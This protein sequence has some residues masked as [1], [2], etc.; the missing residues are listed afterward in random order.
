MV[1]QSKRE[2]LAAILTRYGKAGRMA[3]RRILDEFCSICGHHRKHA[4]RLLN[5]PA[6]RTRQRPGRPATYGAAE[7]K[8]LEALW[9]SANRPCALRLKAAIPLWL[10]HYERRYGALAPEVRQHLPEIS[11]RTLDRLLKP[12]RRKHGQRGR[13]GTRP[14][15]QL[16]HR[17]P[18]K[19]DH[20][21]VQIPGVME[22]DT[23]GHC[24]A[25]M[26]GNFLWS[27]TLTDIY[28][29]WTVNRAVWNKGYDG[30]KQAIQDIEEH[31]PFRLSGFHSDNG[32]EFLNYH[33]V[34]YFENRQPPVAF[35]R[36]RPYHKNDTAHVEQKNYTHVR[37]LLGY[38]RIEEPAL[39]DPI[40]EL[41]RAW[42]LF[43]NFFCPSL[44]LLRKEKVGSRYIKQYDTPQTPHQRLMCSSEIPE[45]MKTSLTELQCNLD[46]FGLRQQ[47]DH[48]Q[49]Q[50]LSQ[51]R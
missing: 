7:C 13:C 45:L 25:R 14:A 43:N 9:L 2:Y 3:K 6:G 49:S 32:G 41:Y 35:S 30:V 36:G 15:L 40:N 38:S 46:P 12:V 22:A 28:S 21:D 8:V 10:A 19:T 31:L 33:L 29:G 47:I 1:Q 37:L 20:A 48:K 17:I 34:R 24:G 4:I 42:E 26:D 11:P 5:R 27:L 50:I 44:K 39:C 23:V 18:V 51:L 16:K